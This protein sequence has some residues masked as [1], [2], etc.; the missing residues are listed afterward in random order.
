MK[1]ERINSD[2]K[3]I[4]DRAIYKS[5]AFT[6]ELPT[7]EK[8]TWSRIEGPDVAVVVPVDE[9]YNVHMKKEYRLSQEREILELPSGKIEK[10][11]A[12]PLL[13][14]QRELAEELGLEAKTWNLLIDTFFTNFAAVQVSIF[15]ARDLSHVEKQPDE[16]E[17]ITSRIMS[18]RGLL[19]HLTGVPTNAQTLL[20]VMLAQNFLGISK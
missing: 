9:F 11:D 2:Q 13:A 6:V 7:T 14:A 4:A 10:N 8:V 18:L 12:S 15:L 1:I 19:E 5:A 17:F 16:H 3:Q 20:G